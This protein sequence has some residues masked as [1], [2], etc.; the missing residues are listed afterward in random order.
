[1]CLIKQFNLY[2]TANSTL[3]LSLTNLARSSIRYDLS[4]LLVQVDL[5]PSSAFD[6]AR[7][8]L[9][10][11]NLRPYSTFDSVHSTFGLTW[12]DLTRLSIRPSLAWP[13]SWPS[14]T[15]SPVQSSLTF[16]PPSLTFGLAQLDLTFGPTWLDFLDL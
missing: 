13:S 7:P 12:T 15:F 8:S 14:T 11:L 3:F 4:W 5:R 10:Q 9:T 2:F 1:M 6:S 16:S